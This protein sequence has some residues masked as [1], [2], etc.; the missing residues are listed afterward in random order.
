M[1]ADFTLGAYTGSINGS[2]NT[3]H[4]MSIPKLPPDFSIKSSDSRVE[5]TK[6][7]ETSV[8]VPIGQINEFDGVV[9]LTNCTSNPSIIVDIEPISGIPP[10]EATLK[11]RGGEELSAGDHKI[12]IL[13]SGITSRGEVIEHK[14]EIPVTILQTT[15]VLDANPKKVISCSENQSCHSTNIDVKVNSPI[16]V[17]ECKF[18]VRYDPTVLT[19]SHR[20][21]GQFFGADASIDFIDR[22]SEGLITVHIKGKP[23]KG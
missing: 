4:L 20:T 5:L 16:E 15:V 8:K 14:L 12:C 18:S 19:T 23:S 7:M 10:F 21:I 17:G 1:A 11:I 2:D 22:S 9:T 13:A 3:V 6:R